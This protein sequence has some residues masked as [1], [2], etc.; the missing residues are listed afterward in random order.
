MRIV[1]EVCFSF[2]F[3]RWL[4]ERFGKVS[5]LFVFSKGKLLAFWITYT[6]CVILKRSTIGLISVGVK[7]E[8]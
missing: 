8:I 1:V 6:D 5:C 4:F 7:Q 3:M 2:S